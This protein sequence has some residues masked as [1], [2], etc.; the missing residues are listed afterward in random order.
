MYSNNLEYLRLRV[1]HT[2][3]Y[4][5]HVI[6]S[7]HA[8]LKSRFAP[9]CCIFQTSHIGLTSIERIW[10]VKQRSGVAVKSGL[11]ATLALEALRTLH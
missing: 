3:T 2:S 5:I 8:K 4:N 7:Y 11:R 9:R 6:V 1:C 10:K